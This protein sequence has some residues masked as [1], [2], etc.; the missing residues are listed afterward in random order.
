MSR[1]EVG[2]VAIKYGKGSTRI[3]QSDVLASYTNNMTNLVEGDVAGGYQISCT[4]TQGGCG[5]PNGDAG[6]LIV[7]KD[8]ISWNR[9]SCQFEFNK[10]ASCWT[11]LGGGNATNS[12][13]DQNSGY[14]RSGP[15]VPGAMSGS[16]PYNSS[17]PGNIWPYNESLG[18][19]YFFEEN[20]FSSNS[21]YIIKAHACDNE[22]TNMLHGAYNDAGYKTFWTTR[23]RNENGNNAG[24]FF[25]RSCSS[26]GAL[27]LVKN[28]YVWY[29]G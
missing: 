19:K 29:E 15:N 8:D 3:T 16:H 21:N 9:I 2:V 17:S 6:L 18:D 23:R 1:W 10:T 20:T 26:T 14:G 28:I 5:N 22:P 12:A 11:F 24:I 27:F 25:G 4:N 7:L 13:Q